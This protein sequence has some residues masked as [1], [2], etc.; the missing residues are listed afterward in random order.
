VMVQGAT[1]ETVNAPE[2]VRPRGLLAA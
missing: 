1:Q 2:L